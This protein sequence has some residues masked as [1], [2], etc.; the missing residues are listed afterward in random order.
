[1]VRRIA[2][3]VNDRQL[4]M[5]EVQGDIPTTEHQGGKHSVAEFCESWSCQL[6][7]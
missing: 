6:E 4:L 1:M 3:R 2:A 7:A 5:L